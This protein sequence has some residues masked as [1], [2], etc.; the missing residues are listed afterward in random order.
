MQNHE[1]LARE[2]L[3]VP[4]EALDG[5]S[6]HVL[7]RTAGRRHIARNTVQSQQETLSRGE[8]AADAVARFGGSWVFIALFMT[9]MVGWT[10]VNSVLLMRYGQPFD[11]Y[12]YILLNLFL[13]MLAA[14]QAPILLM[15]A[16]RQ[17][18][19]DRDTAEHDYEVNLKAELEIMLLHQ[20]IDTLR[21]R[22]WEDLVAMQRQQ[23]ELLDV[24][25]RRDARS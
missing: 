5:L 14:V 7:R 19:K 11:P 15:S 3:G 21:E 10:F 1:E 20:K 12:P 23:L 13:S 24:L 17:A 9:V 18:Q 6:Q 8:R 2:L 25:A 22:Q 16:N 4:Y